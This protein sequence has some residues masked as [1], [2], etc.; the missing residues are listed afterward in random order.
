MRRWWKKQKKKK[1]A[2]ACKARIRVFASR[3]E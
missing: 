1:G 3:K 2:R